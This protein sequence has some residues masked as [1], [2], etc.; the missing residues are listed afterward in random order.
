MFKFLL[1]QGPDLD[2]GAFIS[3]RNFRNR[4]FQNHLVSLY[5]LKRQDDLINFLYDMES[6]RNK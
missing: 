4:D 6:E 1:L 3:H 2:F 5:S